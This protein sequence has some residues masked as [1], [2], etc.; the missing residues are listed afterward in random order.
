M[1]RPQRA[2]GAASPPGWSPQRAIAL[3]KTRLDSVRD[4][5]PPD[6]VPVMVAADLIAGG[7]WPVRDQ[8]HRATCNAFAVIAAEEA[9]A[10]RK[11]GV[12]TRLSEEYLYKAMRDQQKPAGLSQAEQAGIDASGATFLMQART[13]I[14]EVG[15][16]KATGTPYDSNPKRPASYTLDQPRIPEAVL[17]VDADYAHNIAKSKEFQYKVVFAQDLPDGV[18]PLCDMFLRAL[19][20]GVPVVAS[21]PLFARVGM[22]AFSAPN[23]RFRGLVQFPTA[24][25]ATRHQAASG[26]TV[27][28]LGYLPGPPGTDILGGQFLCRNSYGRARFNALA[29]RD[30]TGRAPPYRGYGYIRAADIEVFCWEYLIRA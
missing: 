22:A 11:T 27:C 21:L 3:A 23:A 12:L 28:L 29:N 5:V 19:R 7:D 13:A 15:L 9:L 10:F 6:Q 26:H 18:A 8:A 2:G 1:T 24:E 30:E 20:G 16:H 4:L 17:T 25:Q 14:A